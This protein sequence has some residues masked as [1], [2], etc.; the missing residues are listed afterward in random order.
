ML[1]FK[2]SSNIVSVTGSWENTEDGLVK[3]QISIDMNNEYL[4]HNWELFLN[5]DFET[6]Q[7]WNAEE[8]DGVLTAKDYNTVMDGQTK[9]NMI[10]CTKTPFET[11]K[12]AMVCYQ[13][14]V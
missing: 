12:G 13:P 6:I 8:N 10:L 14:Q 2:N 1:N 9:L 5:T 4:M 11:P 3:N 7:V